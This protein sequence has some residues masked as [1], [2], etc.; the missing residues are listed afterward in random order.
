M[1]E[2]RPVRPV[3]A[4][5]AEPLYRRWRSWWLPV[6]GVVLLVLTLM[7][8]LAIRAYS[9]TSPDM[10]VDLEISEGRNP[11][12]NAVALGVHYGIGPL[13]AVILLAA[14]CLW[15]AVVRKDLLQ[16]L[17]F[18]SI[19]SIG[20]L[21][22]EI[23]KVVVARVRPPHE[24]LHAL[25]L[26]TGSASFPSGHTAF[27]AALSWAVVLVL[28]RPGVQRRWLVAAAIVFT[29]GVGLSR[30]YLGVHYPTDVTA[31]VVIA[32][33]A[34]LIWLPIWNRLIEPALRGSRLRPRFITGA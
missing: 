1:P 20:W 21:S 22:S 26:E 7:V 24:T 15:L 25:V 9:V 33:A 32:T 17:T 6:P 23:G 4:R 18:G 30:L 34:L 28:T 11:L 19:T 8:G 3:P 29:V 16:A 2:P 14:I 31:S 27:A 12:L 10:T 5:P 13:G